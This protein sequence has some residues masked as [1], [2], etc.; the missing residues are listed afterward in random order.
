MITLLNGEQWQEADILKRMEDD[1]FYY[2]HLGQHA[3]SSSSLKKILQSPKA[4]QKS[5]RFSD[6]GQALRD[7]RLVH[8]SIL[9]PHK[10]K[11]LIVINGTKAKKEF[12]DAV[13]EHG[14]HMVYTESEMQ[15]AYWVAD[16]LNNNA[17]AKFLIDDC[18]YEIPGVG[19]LDGLAF[20]AKA[21]A[22]SKDGR[23]I[24]DIKTTSSDVN[25]FHWSAK[26]YQYDLQSA[27]Y[28]ELFE[29]AVEFIF[30]VINKDTKDI[31]IFECSEQFIQN[32][33]NAVE[34]G[35][36]T[37]KYYFMQDNSDELIKNHVIRGIL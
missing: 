34:H 11:D 10:I 18:D 12:K 21:D 23:R 36:S 25:D 1:S 30:L 19:M 7:G 2:G 3:L 4:Y 31:G 35:I 29:S 17:E 28:L 37:Y 20:R 33:R 26:K 24:I 22:L 16:A 6:T 27:L 9:E 5:L 13:E 15:S 8:M 14:E 32:G